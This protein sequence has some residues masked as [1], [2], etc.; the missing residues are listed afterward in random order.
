MIYFILNPK[1]NVVKIGYTEKDVLTRLAQLKTGNSEPLVVVT[2]I[3][4][5]INVEK[6]LHAKF[7]KYRK[8]GEWFNLSEEIIKF[9]NKTHTDC[10]EI[11]VD[12]P[13]KINKNKNVEIINIMKSFKFQENVCK[14][15]DDEFYYFESLTNEWEPFDYGKF[16]QILLEDYEIYVNKR[17]IKGLLEYVVNKE[18]QNTKKLLHGFNKLDEKI[19]Q[20]VKNNYLENNQ[21]FTLTKILTELD[22]NIS[23]Y[24]MRAC[25]LLQTE[26]NLKKPKSP[27]THNN[28]RARWWNNHA[29]NR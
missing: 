7:A 4:G 15:K 17:S 22:L 13:K 12:V 6:S 23:K 21:P 11:T 28:K 29:Q 8:Q 1:L 18:K 14:G 3:E 2:T 24:Q 16:L 27:S 9:I 19:L 25:E 20:H 10:K 26:F 5:D